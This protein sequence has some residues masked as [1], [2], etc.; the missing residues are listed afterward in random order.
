[1]NTPI[2]RFTLICLIVFASLSCKTKSKQEIPHLRKQ[3]T[4][5]QLIVDGKPFLIL[6]GE[7]YNSSASN[8]EYMKPIWPKLFKMNLNT[9]LAT[10]TWEQFEPIEGK[11]DYALVDGLIRDAQQ[12]KLHLVFLWFGSWK[13]G[14]SRYAADWVKADQKRFPRVKDKDGNTL[15][16][17]STLGEETCKA[18]ARAYAALMKHIREVDALKQTVLMMQVENEV[19]MHSDSRDRC[20]E[21]N[22]AFAKPVP[23]ELMDFLQKHKENLLPEL[24]K[25]WETTNYKTSG[26][27][28]DVFGQSPAADEIFM[29][30]N[31]S[32][33]INRVAEAGKAEYPLPMYVNA[34]L[35]QPQD[36]V[37]GDYPSGG[38]VDHVHDIWRAGA[39]QIDILAPD[40]YVTDFNGTVARYSRS[41]NPMFV[42]ESGGDTLGAANAFFAIGQ[43]GS[44]GYSPFG[45]DKEN[46][47]GPL[48][49]A[50]AILAQ[51]SPLILKYQ[52]TGSMGAA[53]LNKANPTQILTLAN[54]EIRI[55]LRKNFWDPK[56]SPAMGYG[57]IISL[58][59]DE[60]LA[61]GND[62]DITFQPSHSDSI[63][64]LTS[65]EEGKFLNGNWIPGRRLNGDEVQLRYD[66]AVAAK[67][68]QSGAGLRF[69]A[70]QYSIQKVKLYK[71]R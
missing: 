3:G 61:A 25:V 53:S 44:M 1:M 63:A 33:F 69:P 14:N 32:R 16:I 38:P 18:D 60:F 54:Y 5:T 48:P 49:K 41:G 27:W 26:T 57:I 9:V 59:K 19:G 39:P 67:E 13:N 6:G 50:Y 46:E 20:A 66:L 56:D 70:N 37:P 17:L 58:G 68:R 15:E 28:E 10:V 21:A 34:W 42:P 2:L 35:V 31:Y 7:L 43:Y 4:A 24:L 11:Y 47:N 62:V 45:I 71:Y 55:G 22:E 65:V 51:L 12:N 40:I 30:W 36:K 23:K 8:L 64:G 29:A 52:G